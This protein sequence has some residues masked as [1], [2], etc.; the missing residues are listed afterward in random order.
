MTMSL[1]AR[2]LI[3]TVALVAVGLLIAQ[4]VRRAPVRPE[5]AYA[6]RP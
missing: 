5:P 1:R 4:A 2:L 6:T 3:T